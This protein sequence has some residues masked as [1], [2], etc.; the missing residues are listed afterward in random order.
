MRF[1]FFFFLLYDSFLIILIGHSDP[2]GH[3]RLCTFPAL[4]L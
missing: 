2:P 1:M 4:A 3:L